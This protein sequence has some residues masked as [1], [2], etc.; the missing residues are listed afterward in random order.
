MKKILSIAV[1]VFLLSCQNEVVDK[2]SLVNNY[3]QQ[4]FEALASE[5]KEV[6]K[7]EII[8]EIQ[9]AIDSLIDTWVNAELVDTINFPGKPIKPIK[10]PAI[11][12]DF[13]KFSLDSLDIK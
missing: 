8:K 2:Q 9:I 5:K 13:Q 6:C 10:P 4:R 7:E 3:Y 11:I 12:N 1:I